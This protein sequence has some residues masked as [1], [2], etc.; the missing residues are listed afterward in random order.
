LETNVN[1]KVNTWEGKCK[2]IFERIL[3][4]EGDKEE[5]KQRKQKK[6]EV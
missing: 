4:E 1:K 5:K 6:E 2:N 3:N